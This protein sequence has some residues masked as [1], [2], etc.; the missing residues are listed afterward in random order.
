M[1]A[2]LNRLQRST[3]RTLLRFGAERSFQFYAKTKDWDAGSQSSAPSGDPVKA[4][5]ARDVEMRSKG[6]GEGGK[7]VRHRV[8]VWHVEVLAFKERG[9]L[10]GDW[11]VTIDGTEHRIQESVLCDDETYYVVRL[12]TGG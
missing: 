7:T 2:T 12:G 4:A 9:G 6:S 1:T 3:R 8:E 11:R 5:M 10:D